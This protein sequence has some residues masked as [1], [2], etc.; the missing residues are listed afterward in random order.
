MKLVCGFAV[1]HIVT[2]YCAASHRAAWSIGLS[3]VLSVC[4]T[5]EP[6]ITAEMIKLPFGFRT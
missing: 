4:H 1:Y 3:V 2:H 5:S 6:C